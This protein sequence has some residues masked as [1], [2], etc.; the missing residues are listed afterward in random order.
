MRRL[1]RCRSTLPSAAFSRSHPKALRIPSE[2]TGLRWLDAGLSNTLVD[3]RRGPKLHPG[4]HGLDVRDWL[5]LDDESGPSSYREQ[6]ALKRSFLSDPEQRP[7]VIQDQAPHTLGAQAEVLEMVLGHLQAL[8]QLDTLPSTDGM[9]PLEA[10]ARLVAEDLILMEERAGSYRSV[11]ACVA[12]SFGDVPRRI[13]EAYSMAELHAKVGRYAQ[14]LHGPTERFMAALT[15][16]RPAWRVNWNLVFSGRLEPHPDRYVQNL[17]KRQRIF[18]HAPI[19]EWDGPDG[20][21]RR[22]DEYG[23]ADT[24]FVKVEFQTFRR[25]ERHPEYVLFG[26]R[27][28]V[29]PMSAIR[30]WPDAA[31]ALAAN[32]RRAVQTEFRFFKGL[33]DERIVSRALAYLDACNPAPD[34]GEDASPRAPP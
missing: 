15:C 2:H 29:E 32:I 9:S 4:L 27:T 10:A 3:T 8:D 23:V 33:D 18:P 14:D 11:A 30:A 17:E 7:E 6:V 16:E 24:L 25:L 34:V 5:L 1:A 31:A 28:F 13:G 21:V 19:T 22:L 26:I 20:A 12:F